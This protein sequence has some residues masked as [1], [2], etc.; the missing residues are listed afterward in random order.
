MGARRARSL[1]ESKLWKCAPPKSP[2]QALRLQIVT[3]VRLGQAGRAKI[4]SQSPILEALRGADSSR[5]YCT[6]SIVTVV[7]ITRLA[8]GDCLRSCSC[9]CVP[10]RPC[11][12]LFLISVPVLFRMG[13]Q[14]PNVSRC[15]N[16]DCLWRRAVLD[17]SRTLRIG[18]AAWPRVPR[19]LCPSRRPRARRPSVGRRVPLLSYIFTRSSS[20]PKTPHEKS[21]RPEADESTRSED[22]R[23]RNLG[24]R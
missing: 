10:L 2:G 12:D 24:P 22:L 18:S 9:Y 6:I 23:E 3:L 4:V 11:S 13:I 8:S 21:E 19:G 14:I 1:S 16:I 5:S 15:M 7:I 17:Q 20:P